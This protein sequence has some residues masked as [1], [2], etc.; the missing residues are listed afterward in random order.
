MPRRSRHS[1]RFALPLP[2]I[3]DGLARS[4][5][6]QLPHS[7]REWRMHLSSAQH[8]SRKRGVTAVATWHLTLPPQVG[9]ASSGIKQTPSVA[10]EG[11]CLQFLKGVGYGGEVAAAGTMRQG[12]S[13]SIRLMVWPSAILARISRR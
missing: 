7:V 10:T 5:Y 6:G 11:V 1:R 12:S 2:Q 4:G 13:S 8:I 3:D 9:A